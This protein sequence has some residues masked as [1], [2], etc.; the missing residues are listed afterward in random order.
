MPCLWWSR[1]ELRVSVKM[2]HDLIVVGAGT[3]GCMAAK[4]AAEGGLGVL[5]I[6]S[7]PRDE[8]GDTACGNVVSAGDLDRVGI[9]HPKDICRVLKGVKVFSP[10]RGTVFTINL[11]HLVLDRRA[12]GQKLL[13]DAL[14]AGAE[15]SDRTKALGPVMEGRRAVG[16]KTDKG[17]MPSKLVV[18]ASGFQAV[19]R[20]KLPS[21][22]KVRGED[23]G[24][25]YLEV[26]KLDEQIDPNYFLIYLKGVGNGYCWVT[27]EGKNRANI[28]IGVQGASN[29]PSPKALFYEHVFSRFNLENSKLI[30]VR[31]GVVPTRGPIN[32]LYSNGVMFVG[33]AGCQTNPVS[34]SGIGLSLAAGRIAGGGRSRSRR[35]RH[36]PEGIP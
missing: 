28:G 29:H 31:G 2:R 8:I 24:V 21:A 33:D 35:G 5:L 12:F 16:I 11:K 19:I 22:E 20:N 26:R 27:P 18:D 14:R 3:A 36:E 15:F 17:K 32:P 10:D 4:T 9:K 1:S 13:S 25:C 6:D 7:K 34:A 30:R 23:T